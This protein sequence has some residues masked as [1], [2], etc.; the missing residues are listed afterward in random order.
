MIRAGKAGG[1]PWE[2]GLPARFADKITK[3]LCVTS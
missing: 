3:T 2:R 1:Q